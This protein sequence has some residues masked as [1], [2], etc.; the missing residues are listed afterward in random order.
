M[1]E[2]IEIAG[3]QIKPGERRLVQVPV[4]QRLTTGDVEINAVVIHG[5]KPGPR[6]FVSAALALR[7]KSGSS[8]HL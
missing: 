5:R 3:V 2:P 8:T 4:A 7:P 1:Q 6:L